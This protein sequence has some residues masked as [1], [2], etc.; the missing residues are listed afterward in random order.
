MSDKW[1]VMSNEITKSSTVDKVL[2]V[3]GGPW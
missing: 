1:V 2:N 3:D